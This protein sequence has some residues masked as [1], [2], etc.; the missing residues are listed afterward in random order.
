MRLVLFL[1]LLIGSL[2]AAH[3]QKRI[4]LSFDDVPR[5]A[6]AFYTPDER[7][8]ALIEALR[9]GGVEQAA[10]FVTT[11]HLA[12]PHGAGGEARIAAYVAAGHVIA[13]HS[14]SHLWLHRT[15]AAE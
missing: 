15:D 12:K 8:S 2:S 4:A 1:L 3:A 13:N 11:G 14:H 7:A 6:G 10:F 9:N 5:Q